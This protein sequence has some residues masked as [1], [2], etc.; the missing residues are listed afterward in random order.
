MLPWKRPRPEAPCW[1][2]P[3]RI[4]GQAGRE[5][6]RLAG[7][8]KARERSRIAKREKALAGVAD[9]M[10]IMRE[11]RAGGA[12]LGAI[13]TE[14]NAAGHRTTRGN[15]WTAMGIKLALDRAAA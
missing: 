3:A 7:L 6:T 10:P 9:L 13:A 11:R 1:G 4:I 14:L 15:E 12:S 2:A 5:D 8:A